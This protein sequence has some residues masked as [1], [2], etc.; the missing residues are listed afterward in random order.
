MQRAWV[1]VRICGTQLG[2]AS[3]RTDCINC[4]SCMCC[5]I[6]IYIVYIVYS[7]V[8]F[9]YISVFFFF[10]VHRSYRLLGKLLR[11]SLHALPRP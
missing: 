7:Y 9:L 1:I 3:V 10:C 5:N 2:Q 4:I 11:T 6:L 8:L